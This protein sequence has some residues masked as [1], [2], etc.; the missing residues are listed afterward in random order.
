MSWVTSFIVSHH[1][2]CPDDFVQHTLGATL[3]ASPKG[4]EGTHRQRARFPVA[5]V[6]SLEGEGR[7][8]LDGVRGGIDGCRVLGGVRTLSVVQRVAQKQRGDVA[9]DTQHGRRQTFAKAAS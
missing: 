7:L 5:R 9:R 4:K 1:D 2:R 3:G 8:G 6:Q